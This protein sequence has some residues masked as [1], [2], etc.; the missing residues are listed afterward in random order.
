MTRPSR[1]TALLGCL[2]AALVAVL[3]SV[4]AA[5]AD[6]RPT[7]APDESL[8]VASQAAAWLAGSEIGP[9]GA[10]HGAD[11]QPD[12]VATA[13]SVL[14]LRAAGLEPESGRPAGW[15][16]GHVDALARENDQDSPAG[17]ALL[18]LVAVAENRPPQAFGG[19][20]LVGRLLGTRRDDGRFG[21]ADSLP[22]TDPVGGVP[23]RQAV[24]LS[25]LGAAG[26]TDA[27][28]AEWLEA[29]QC[30][31]GGW[32]FQ[33]TDPGTR[34]RPTPEVT[35]YAMQGLAAVGRAVPPSAVDALGRLEQDDG[36]F[37]RP[38]TAGNAFGTAIALQGLLAAGQDP[39]TARWR[40]G[41]GAGA[42]SP[43]FALLRFATDRSGGFSLEPKGPPD[44]SLTARVVLAAAG[45]PLPIAAADPTLGDA[46]GVAPST[47][48]GS[49]SAGSSGSTSSSESGGTTTGSEGFSP[50]RLLGGAVVVI[51]VVASIYA[52]RR[53]RQAL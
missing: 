17:L 46:N 32:Q 28:A 49:D 6:V 33:R 47:P 36:T 52:Y 21:P 4:R 51:G 38:G 41:T 40:K 8:S 11:G 24:V 1:T 12:A 22:R 23:A 34:C 48:G 37:S 44:P 30:P 26:R 9:D 18:V 45:Q 5:A 35:G 3:P 13:W 25:A 10:I 53:R 14:A 27:G 19:Q 39:N 15:L 31:D 20:D 16:E 2:L 50:V 43:F 7:L 29:R 42:V